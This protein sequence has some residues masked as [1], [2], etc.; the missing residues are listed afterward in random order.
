MIMEQLRQMSYNKLYTIWKVEKSTRELQ[1]LPSGF[2]KELSEYI[3]TVRRE[4]KLVDEK[5]LK[6]SLLKVEKKN[7]EYLITDLLEAR[8]LKFIET[9]KIGEI[10]NPDIIVEEESEINASLLLSRRSL[11]QLLSNISEGQ[12]PRVE[13]K[14]KREEKPKRILVRFLQSVPAIVGTDLKLYG[15]FKVED[16]ATLPVENAEIFIKRGIAEQ[17][18]L[19]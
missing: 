12:E 10:I 16:V 1:P 15:P 5:S 6:A 19:K 17:V 11:K 2:Y 7:V 3:S 13:I 4:I 14:I 8:Y 18:N 9:I